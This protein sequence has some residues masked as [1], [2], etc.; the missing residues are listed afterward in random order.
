M[1]SYRLGY[2]NKKGEFKIATI[3]AKTYHQA[4]RKLGE[5]GVVDMMKTLSVDF[6]KLKDQGVDL[7]N[8]TR[9]DYTMPKLVIDV[10]GEV[11]G[12]D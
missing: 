12:D 10:S 4:R 5:S 6:Q 1:R 3:D 9:D 7:D 2:I 11:E 8:P